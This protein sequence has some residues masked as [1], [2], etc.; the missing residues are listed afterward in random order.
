MYFKLAF[1][2]FLR[3]PWRQGIVILLIA[4]ATSLPVFIFQ[5]TGGLYNGINNAISPF[6]I[7]VGT[8]GSA[9]QL[10]FN[11]VFLKDKP[12]GNMS[13]EVVNKLRN[14]GKTQGVYPLAF[15]DNYRG[16]P[17]VG[18]EKEMFQYKLKPTENPW[19]SVKKGRIYS[20]KREVV[21]GNKVAELS[22]LKIGDTFSS[23]HGMHEKGTKHSGE[24]KVVG[25]LAPVNGPYDLAIFTDI[26]DVWEIH[27][28]PAWQEKGDVTSLLI[29]PKGYKEA[30]QLLYEYQKNKDTQMIFPSQQIISLYHI[31]GQT[32][33]FWQ[34]L[35][36]AILGLSLFISI[37]I[38]YW[39]V[40]NRMKEFALLK[41]LGS[42]E[43]DIVKMILIEEAILLMIGVIIGWLSAYSFTCVLIH[44]ISSKTAII[45]ESKPLLESLLL[46]PSVTVL[47]TLCS[48]IP[49]YFIKDKNL[50]S[51]L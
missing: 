31:V 18:V 5:M 45:I 15:G 51:Y 13:Y 32:K 33:E 39:S 11:T 34:I 48:I 8:K 17:I 42:S 38:M 29:H 50:A 12:L 3:R 26:R 2:S 43:R 37:L 41:A 4:L 6:P 35:T 47:G 1:L 44:V 21:I 20:E 27:H 9:Y 49:I 36:A 30:L 23:I 19:L 10:V 40:K 24:N 25:I 7:I 46:I 16:F 14:S 28:L 22:G